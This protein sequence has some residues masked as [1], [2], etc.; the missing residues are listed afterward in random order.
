MAKAI[1]LSNN[2]Y[3]DSTSINHNR[4]KLSDLLNIDIPIFKDTDLPT[5]KQ[6]HAN[7]VGIYSISGNNYQ[8]NTGLQIG[9]GYRYG[10]VIIMKMQQSNFSRKIV[11]AILISGVWLGIHWNDNSDYWFQLNN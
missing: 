9:D 1:E 11:I 10:E 5:N 2:V 3:L 6:W 8:A 7:D 4:R